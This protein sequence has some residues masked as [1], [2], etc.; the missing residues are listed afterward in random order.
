MTDIIYFDTDCVSAFLWVK[1]ENILTSL[2]PGKIALPQQVYNE[3]SHPGTPQLKTRF[4]RLVSNGDA[5]IC[6]ILTATPEYM[7]YIKLTNSPDVGHSIIGKGEASALALAVEAKGIIASNNLK[8]VA[9][10]V[11]K[12]G[13]RHITTGDILVKALE[14]SLISESD[15]NNIWSAMLLKRR[16]LGT[17]TFSDYLKTHPIQ[18]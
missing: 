4:D 16:K 7:L 17:L 2:F 5:T 13:L 6:P 1:E 3:L 12:F 14:S 9:V 18:N 8:D 11:L 10:Y 15:G